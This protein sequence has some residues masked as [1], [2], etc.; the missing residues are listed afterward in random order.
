MGSFNVTLTEVV[1]YHGEYTRDDVLDFMALSPENGSVVDQEI[2]EYY[3][4]LDDSE[5]EL[6]FL[7]ELKLHD[8]VSDAVWQDIERNSEVQSNNWSTES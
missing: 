3:D 6:A 1:T 4:K 7:A 5:L 8:Y 2:R